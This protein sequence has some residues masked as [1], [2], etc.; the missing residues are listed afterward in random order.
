MWGHVYLIAGVVSAW[1]GGREGQAWI[2]LLHEALSYHMHLGA[3][4]LSAGVACSPWEAVPG[5][6]GARK[7]DPHPGPDGSTLGLGHP[8]CLGTTKHDFTVRVP[9]SMPQ[10][11]P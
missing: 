1:T 6:G 2:Q 5:L 11:H 3:V 8:L 10:G 9:H 4:V 7:Q